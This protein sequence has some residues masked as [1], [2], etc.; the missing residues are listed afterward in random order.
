MVFKLEVEKNLSRDDLLLQ[1]VMMHYTRN[2]IEFSSGNFR[3]RGDI[4]EIFPTYEEKTAYRIE[5]YFDEIEKIS[6]IDPLTGRLIEKRGE[7]T[8]F[9]GSHHVVPKRKREE[10]LISIAEELKERVSYYE[11]KQLFTEA[12]RIAQ[13]T[14]YDMEMI[15]RSGVL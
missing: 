2:D 15:Q 8:L 14:N 3:V 10:A 7:L 1:L 13:R 9:P 12:S 4:V 5:F 6:I 11:D